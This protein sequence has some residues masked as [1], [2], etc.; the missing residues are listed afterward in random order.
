MIHI[1]TYYIIYSYI[2]ASNNVTN[3]GGSRLIIFSNHPKTRTLSRSRCRHLPVEALPFGSPKIAMCPMRPTI[4]GS[5]IEILDSPKKTIF[6]FQ[7]LS[8]QYGINIHVSYPQDPCMPYMVTWIP[9]LYPLYVSIN[10][11]APWIRHGIWIHMVYPYSEQACAIPKSHGS[12]VPP[13]S[14]GLFVGPS[15][16]DRPMG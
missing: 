7:L 3:S 1:H 14:P 6:V 11:P 16:L 10:I 4:F 5:S 2:F 15:L 13:R 8:P 12:P 9:S